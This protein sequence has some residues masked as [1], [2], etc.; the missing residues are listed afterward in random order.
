MEKTLTLLARPKNEQLCGTVLPAKASEWELY[1]AGLGRPPPRAVLGPPP[2]TSQVQLVQAGL[3]GAPGATITNTLGS[4]LTELRCKAVGAQPET[5][6]YDITWR[7]NASLADV[8]A[9]NAG[10]SMP[11]RFVLP[12][13]QPGWEPTYFG[14]DAAFRQFAGGF[15]RP[16]VYGTG[17]AAAAAAAGVVD[18]RP[19]QVRPWRA[20]AV[21]GLPGYEKQ[22]AGERC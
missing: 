15:Q 4:C 13:Y 9:A 20:M 16:D 18:T 22:K 17:L 3:F 6:M 1:Y 5:N 11:G 7:H 14:G 8:V 2:P 19:N 12:C 10:G 21:E